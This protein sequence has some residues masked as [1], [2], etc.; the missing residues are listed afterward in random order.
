MHSTYHTGPLGTR[1]RTAEM[2][3][4]DFELR[5]WQHFN[6]LSGDQATPSKN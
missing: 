3:D 6:W 1:A 4:M 2:T 5:N